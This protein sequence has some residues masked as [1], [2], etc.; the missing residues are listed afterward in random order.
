MNSRTFPSL[1]SRGQASIK[2]LAASVAAATLLTA[3]GGGSSQST[4][5]TSE[6]HEHTGRLLF[7]LSDSDTLMVFDQEENEFETLA[8]SAAGNAASLLLADNG[9]SA[10]VLSNGIV[11]FVYSGL[12]S[13]EE[14][15]ALVEAEGEH[16]HEEAELLTLS[17]DSVSAMT[18]TQGHFSLLQNGS[19]VLLPAEDLED[20]E[21][22]FENTTGPASQTYPGLVLD[23]EHEL[24][25]FFAAAKA[26]VYEA[27]AATGD[28]FSCSNPAASVQGTEFALVQC[29]EGVL[30]V[31]VEETETDHEIDSA[32]LSALSSA[33]QVRSNGHDFAAFDAASLWLIQEDD[34]EVLQAESVNL[35][36]VSGICDAA[37]AT[38]DEETLAVLNS[39]GYLHI[40]DAES[41][42]ESL[43]AL[44]ETVTTNL[45]CDDLALAN[46]PEGF[47]VADKNDG[48]L[49]IIDAHDGSPY[50]VHSRY[51]DDTLTTLADAVFMHAIDAEHTHEH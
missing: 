17:L 24:M 51:Q 42:A 11:N 12:H 49:Y 38:E 44:D 14:E 32:T 2:T 15:E 36:G 3:C 13:E 23:E 35:T 18:S 28:E 19:T 47:M 45:S 48:I 26:Q 21:L 20:T 27:G 9:L 50:H 40:I 8:D 5:D 16:D 46:G 30:T 39:A 37:F 22:D 43:I 25:L 10:A 41:G 4:S 33:T 34:N 6:E 7:S 1:F 29:D 31:K